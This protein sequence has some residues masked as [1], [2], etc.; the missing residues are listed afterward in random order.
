MQSIQKWNEAAAEFQKV[1]QIGMNDYSRELL[2]FLLN[3]DMLYPGCRVIDVGCGVGKY[4]TYFATLG[5]DVTLTDISSGMLAMAAQNMSRFDTP[6]AT[7]ECDF[8]EADPNHPVLKKGFDLGISTMCPA[9][10]DVD[11]VKKFSRMIHG[12]CFIT[13]F[14]SWEEPMRKVFYE[15][16]GIRPEEDMNRFANH[17]DHLVQAVRDAG[18][19]PNIQYVPYNWSD[20]RTPE[21]AAR[22][23]LSRFEDLEITPQL[24]E[25]AVSAAREL[26]NEAGVFVDSVNTN[27]AWV[28]W[29]TKGDK[30]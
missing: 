27:V 21:E 19:E 30:A 8:R 24:Q 4:G 22:Y 26:C 23:L 14:V 3:N 5:C 13:H 1:F 10:R 2:S 9:I 11:A 12:W 16:L 15:K 18:Y 20:D 28:W 29:N 7:L 17:I 6:W 25:K